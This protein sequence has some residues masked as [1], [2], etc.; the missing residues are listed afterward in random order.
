MS[1][2]VTSEVERD[3]T[4]GGDGAGESWSF[5]THDTNTGENVTT[6]AYAVYLPDRFPDWEEREDA[7]N[8]WDV[9]T[10]DM[11]ADGVGEYLWPSLNGYETE[12]EADNA[13][14]GLAE[15]YRQVTL[16][17]GGEW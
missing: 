1:V 13:A 9:E 15:H 2:I 5:T 17:H 16:W 10:V 12:A 7:G 8:P 14:R 3:G 11:S 6:Y 4:V